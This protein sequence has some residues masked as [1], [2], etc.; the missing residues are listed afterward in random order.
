MTTTDQERVANRLLRSTANVAY[1][2]DLDIDWSAPLVDGK[3]YVLPHRSSLYGTRL[4]DQ[5]TAE[6]QIEL[7]KHE[8]VSVASTGIFLESVLMRMLAKHAYW[9]EVQSSHIQYALAELGEETRHTIMFAKMTERLGTPRYGPSKVILR[10]GAAL[11]AIAFGP[12]LWG[13]ILIGE[14]IIDRLQREIVA[15][16]SIQPLIR[17]ISRI[18]IVE[19]ARHVGFARAEL[20]RSV[21]KMN[22]FARGYHRITLARTAFIVSRL[23]VNPRVYAA[24]GLD[25]RAARRAALANPYYQETLRYGG[26]KLVA[27]LTEAGLIGRPGS[28]LWRRSFLLG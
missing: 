27:F 6:Q 22:R 3:R 15:D 17:M 9:G 23:M 1:D 24:V 19:E 14:E 25:P 7:G 12:S 21:A 28:Y 26:E 4:F 16:E 18:H 8:I 13:A 2:P 11:T 20:V 5:L 10:M